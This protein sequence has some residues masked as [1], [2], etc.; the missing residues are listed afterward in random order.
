MNGLII[1]ISM[2]FAAFIAY[3][4][5]KS[6]ILKYILS[7][8][9]GVLY[10]FMLFIIGMSINGVLYLVLAIIPVIAGVIYIIRQR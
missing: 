9:V 4:I 5:T 2:S 7:P 1:L 6:K 10:G 3:G 8:I